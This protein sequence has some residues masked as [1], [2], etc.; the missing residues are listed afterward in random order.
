MRLARVLKFRLYYTIQAA[1]NKTARMHIRPHILHMDLVT[2]FTAILSL[3][4]IQ[5]G[6]LSVTEENMGFVLHG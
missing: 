5:V 3:P 4:L 1:N 2:K 6:Q